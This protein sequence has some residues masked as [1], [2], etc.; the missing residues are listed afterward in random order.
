MPQTADPELLTKKTKKIE[1][2]IL[3]LLKEEQEGGVKKERVI[4]EED[5]STE[6]KFGDK[7]V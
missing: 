7:N 5:Q 3:D 6:L 2:E 4:F 1:A